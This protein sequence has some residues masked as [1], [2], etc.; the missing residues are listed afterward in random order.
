MLCKRVVDALEAYP[1]YINTK[2]GALS[3]L[4][5]NHRR[6]DKVVPHPPMSHRRF[7]AV[8][9]RWWMRLALIPPT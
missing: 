5:G 8:Y 2:N 4:A 7:N 3:Q 1:P 9:I 6:G